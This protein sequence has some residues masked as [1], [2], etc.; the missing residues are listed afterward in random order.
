LPAPVPLYLGAE[1][2][3]LPEL[4]RVI[5][6]YGERVVMEETLAKALGAPFKESRLV[7]PPPEKGRPIWMDGMSFREE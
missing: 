1:T 6:A 2:G 3:Q 4:K 5:V 7:S